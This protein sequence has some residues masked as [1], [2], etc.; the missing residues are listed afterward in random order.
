MKRACK[1][2]EKKI[3]RSSDRFG[4]GCEKPLRRLENKSDRYREKR[5]ESLGKKRPSNIANTNEVPTIRVQIG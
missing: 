2:F 4:V 5:E 3:S 1:D